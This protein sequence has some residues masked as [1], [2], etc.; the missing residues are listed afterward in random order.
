[1]PQVPDVLSRVSE[2]RAREFTVVAHHAIF[3]RSPNNVRVKVTINALL[4]G[5]PSTWVF[6]RLRYH[7]ACHARCVDI[8]GPR[9]HYRAQPARRLPKVGELATSYGARLRGL[10]SLHHFRAVQPKELD[11]AKR[12]RAAKREEI[13]PVSRHGEGTSGSGEARNSAVRINLQSKSWEKAEIA[14]KQR[15]GAAVS[16]TAQVC[17]RLPRSLVSLNLGHGGFLRTRCNTALEH[18][19]RRPLH[20]RERFRLLSRD[21]PRGLMPRITLA[22]GQAYDRDDPKHRLEVVAERLVL[23]P[24]LIVEPCIPLPAYALS[25]VCTHPEYVVNPSSAWAY[26]TTE[27]PGLVGTHLLFQVHVYREQFADSD[28]CARYVDHAIVAWR[29]PP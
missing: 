9:W 17:H 12:D 5:E 22:R 27:L 25:H 28:P 23:C 21:R 7:P 14:P 3:S 15:S 20:H 16:R 13:A 10:A 24:L 26:F 4:R 19:S 18:E 29:S 1:M 2:L 11:R 6:G 8:L